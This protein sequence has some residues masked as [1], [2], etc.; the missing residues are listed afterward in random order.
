M[1]DERLQRKL[2]A[3]LYADVAGYSRLSG[4]D[5]DRTHRTLRS[6]LDAFT[7]V[8]QAHQGNVVHFAGD[9]VLADFGTATEALECAAQFQ[10]ELA[11]RN[12]DL[13]PQ[14]RVEF[15]IG[16]NL[17][18]VIIDRNDIY[19]DGVN[20]AARLEALADTGGICISEAV[21]HAVGNKLPLA[22]EFMGQQ[23][24]K[25]IAKP[26][27]TY[28][29]LLDVQ[30]QP[31]RR[32]TFFSHYARGLRAAAVVAVAAAVLGLGW[33]LWPSSPST[34]EGPASAAVADDR[35]SIAV[36]PFDNLSGNVDEDYFSDGITSDLINDLAQVSGLFVIARNSVFTYKGRAM[37]VSQVGQE[38]GVKYIL[39]GS[40]L[41][42]G[43]RV[44]INAQ[45]VDVT[46]EHPMWAERYDRELNDVLTLQDEVTQNIVSALEVTLTPREAHRLNRAQQVDP[47][48][49]DIFLRGLELFRR[50][51]QDTNAEAR[52][53]FKQSAERDP[54]FARAVADVALTY[55]TD[56][57]LGWAD[58]D[59]VKDIALTWA[60]KAMA[61]DE[62]D[63]HVHF[64]LSNLYT[65]L[66]RHGEAIVAAHRAIELDP[67]YADGY[68]A[69][70]LALNHAGQPE[71]AL[72]A[73]ATAKQLNPLHAFYYTWITGQARFFLGRYEEAVRDFREVV[74]RNAQ[75]P[76]GHEMLAATLAHLGEI[77]DAQWAAEELLLLM[78]D[79]SLRRTEAQALY[80]R[81]EDLKRYT[82]GLRRAGLPE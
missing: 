7:T 19:G 20:V 76:A 34:P 13:P 63:P 70:A 5:E 4:Q 39:E 62:S 32:Q 65:N 15:R 51:T 75:F 81:F 6:Y 31:G 23:T 41:R 69:L 1:N 30:A 36:L 26:V 33:W 49:Y 80:E 54:T 73:I 24:V 21:Y 58:A 22:Y 74:E 2:A 56:V 68:A 79:F 60:D 43:N 47:T 9:A 82:D 53:L 78:P 38:L 12:A 48:A 11:A 28:R 50:F 45:L 42:V 46:S 37:K 67:N 72:K 77:E 40:V 66:K 55:S 14:Q 64:A 10:R 52:E 8:I 57:L 44:R 59:D 71:E 35:P 3:I 61:L 17:G 27:R 25:N 18:E 16:I 29:V